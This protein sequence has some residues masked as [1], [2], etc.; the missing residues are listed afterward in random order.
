MPDACKGAF[1]SLTPLVEEPVQEWLGQ[2]G[3]FSTVLLVWGI[4]STLLLGRLL[5]SLTILS[6]HGTREHDNKRARELLMSLQNEL[7]IQRPVRLVIHEG[8]P[9]TWGILRHCVSLPESCHDWSDQRLEL[10]LRHEIAHV[11]RSD[12]LWLLLSQV[13]LALLWFH[14][15]M[16]LVAGWMRREREMAADELVIQSGAGEA[17]Y[18]EVILS[19]S[20]SQRERQTALAMCGIVSSGKGRVLE[21]RIRNVLGSGRRFSGIGGPLQILMVIVVISLITVSLSF[22]VSTDLEKKCRRGSSSCVR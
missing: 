12:A 21:A 8:S 18:A 5:L 3:Q 6:L 15:V 7:G 16:W 1:E 19:F 17:D 2:T 14:P 13:A 20:R 10:A 11:Q 22:A 4:V 9:M